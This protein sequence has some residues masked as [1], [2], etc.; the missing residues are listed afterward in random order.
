LVV[1]SVARDVGFPIMVRKPR[2][3]AP[4]RNI[5]TLMGSIGFS[6]GSG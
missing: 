6:D 1:R 3:D 5:K 4:F 2:R